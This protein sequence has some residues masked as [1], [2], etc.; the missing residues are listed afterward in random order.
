MFAFLA[1]NVYSST[2]LA[3][4]AEDYRLA[5]ERLVTAP[6]GTVMIP[7]ATSPKI[8][9]AARIQTATSSLF[10]YAVEIKQA[11]D[12]ARRQGGDADAD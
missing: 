1:A 4:I 5:A 10:A 11:H 9:L 3:S 6:E 12:P 8:E 7:S 2:E